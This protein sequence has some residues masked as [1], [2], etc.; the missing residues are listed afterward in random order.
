MK[1]ALYSKSHL[2]TA[3]V[4]FPDRVQDPSWYRVPWTTDEMLQVAEVEMARLSTD[5]A[6]TYPAYDYILGNNPADEVKILHRY[7]SAH[8][9][10]KSFL[11]IGCGTAEKEFWLARRHPNVQ[12]TCLDRYAYVVGLAEVAKRLELNNIKFARHNGLDENKVGEFSIV[13]SMGVVFC[14]PDDQ[15]TGFIKNHTQNLAPGGRLFLGCVANISNLLK[16]RLKLW[17]KKDYTGWK[18]IGWMRDAKEVVRFFP[19]E[20]QL[21]R[22]YQ[23]THQGQAPNNIP[24]VG[25]LIRSI[26]RNVFPLSN[27]SY[28]FELTV[29]K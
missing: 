14:I 25:S 20:L 10:V 4:A 3:K 6:G 19:Q 8:S 7:L 13:Y 17:G 22:L 24:L 1:I 29:R 2:E 9:E 11:S 23:I 15:L 27:S 16:L 5:V 26:S 28:L 18:Q 21:E 12:F